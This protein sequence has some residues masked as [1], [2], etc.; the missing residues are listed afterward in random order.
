MGIDII[1][2]DEEGEALVVV[3]DLKINVV[4]AAIAESFAL[5][6]AVE[7]CS[8]L[9]IQKAIFE[10]DANKVVEAVQS[11][12]EAVFAFSS[13]IDD[14]KFLFRNRTDWFIQFVSRKKNTVAHT[15]AKKALAIGEELV[16]IEEVLDFI[17][18]C[19]HN[20]TSYNA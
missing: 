14:V 5:R 1:I 8:E 19:L 17:V 15:L 10:G 16:W 12:K 11:E 4:N 9:N 3:C 6:K 20:D 2:R 7:L 18:G 13:I